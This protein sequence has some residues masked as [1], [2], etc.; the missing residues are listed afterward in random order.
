M[1][2]RMEVR[3]GGFR[4]SRRAGAGGVEGRAM[5][6]SGGFRQER[7]GDTEGFAAGERQ[8]QTCVSRGS[9][10]AASDVDPRGASW[11]PETD[12]REII[13][14]WRQLMAVRGEDI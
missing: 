2:K 3:G 5:L 12:F 1:S 6:M 4:L 8:E 9:Q 10:A 13:M 14:A 11:S 7:W